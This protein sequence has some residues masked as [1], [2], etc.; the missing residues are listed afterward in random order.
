MID[1]SLFK[2]ISD[3]IFGKKIDQLGK[4]DLDQCVGLIYSQLQF[5]L[6]Q[7]LRP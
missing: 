7:K 1:Q 5:A 6:I 3:C 2:L 4:G